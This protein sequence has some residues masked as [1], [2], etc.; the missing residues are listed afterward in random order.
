MKKRI[1]EVVSIE[2]GLP[3]K[4]KDAPIIWDGL[5]YITK[6]NGKNHFV[7]DDGT[8]IP[9]KYVTHWLKDSEKFVFSQE[10][11]IELVRQAFEEGKQMMFMETQGKFVKYKNSTEYLESKGL[12]DKQETT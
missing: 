4:D 10:E 11:L 8:M 6:W 3:E 7:F 12:T 2:D 5:N 1:F 9:V